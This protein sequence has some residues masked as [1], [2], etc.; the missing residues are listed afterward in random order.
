MTIVKKIDIN[1][2]LLSNNVQNTVPEY[3]SSAT[4]ID[5]DIVRYN[6]YVYRSISDNNT[7]N[8]PEE[9][10]YWV[11]WDI[12][13]NKKFPIKYPQN[14]DAMFDY[15]SSSK[16]VNDGN[17]VL[18]FQNNFFNYI[19]G[20]KIYCNQVKVTI[21][22]INSNI[23]FEET[24]DMIE[25]PFWDWYDWTM[26]MPVSQ[27]DSFSFYL[28]VIPQ[29]TIKLELIGDTVSA[30]FIEV[31]DRAKIGCTFDGIEIISKSGKSY[32]RDKETGVMYLNDR[33]KGGYR[34][35]KAS[36]GIIDYNKVDEVLTTLESIKNTP[37]TF[38]AD[39]RDLGTNP[40]TAMKS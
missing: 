18:E 37:T 13:N 19:G 36:V 12:H 40:P 17:I 31:G 38:I 20:H 24:K 33:E 7:G 39:D 32:D 4:Y 15:Y 34:E 1:D 8:N 3:D 35:L 9:T 5:G 6:G 27:R 16:T 30:G 29:T 22:D 11:N 26:D 14:S 28:P 2:F 21:T 23:I 10:L 25:N